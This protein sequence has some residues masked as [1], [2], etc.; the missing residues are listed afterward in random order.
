M[1]YA[2]P[3]QCVRAD[4]EWG[5]QDDASR[6]QQGIHG[7]DLPTTEICRIQCRSRSRQRQSLC[8]GQTHYATVV[9]LNLENTSAMKPISSAWQV[10]LC[11][12]S[13]STVTTSQ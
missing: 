7:T 1:Q 10:F 3:A 12:L 9:L 4:A 8:R 6:M 11:Y 2:C 5:A 13:G